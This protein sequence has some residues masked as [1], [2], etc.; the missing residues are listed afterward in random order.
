MIRRIDIS[1]S[2][3]N[4]YQDLHQQQI[5]LDQVVRTRTPK[6]AIVRCPPNK[7]SQIVGFYRVGCSRKNRI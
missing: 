7:M 1:P 4:F 3:P 5:N 6:S 2:N